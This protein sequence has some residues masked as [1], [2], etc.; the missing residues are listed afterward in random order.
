MGPTLDGADKFPGMIL[1]SHHYKKPE[2][3]KGN[4]VIILGAASSGEDIARD[5]SKIV[6]QAY[7]VAK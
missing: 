7:L 1:H 3:V 4:R 2:D 6:D 5:V